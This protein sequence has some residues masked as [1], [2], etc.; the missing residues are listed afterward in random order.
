MDT[1]QPLESPGTIRRRG[2]LFSIS[3][4]VIA[5][6]AGIGHFIYL[7]NLERQ[8]GHRVPVVVAA[9][10]ISARTVFSEEMLKVIELPESS[11]PEAPDRPFIDP[12]E[13]LDGNTTALINIMPG[14]QIQPNMVSSNL[15]KP[16]YRAVS[17][18]VDPVTSTGGS[19]RTGNY[20]DIVRSFVDAQECSTT[21]FLLQNVLVLD[22]NTDAL[23]P[24]LGGGIPF[25]P[26]SAEGEIELTPTII[27]T[28]ELDQEDALKLI[29]AENFAAELRLIVRRVDEMGEPAIAP[30]HND[31]CAASA[32]ANVR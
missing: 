26:N 5:I 2:W 13:L 28:L 14:Q 1:Q 11:L 19:V 17:I 10:T 31:G 4:V 20:V 30:V 18:A 15:I 7:N 3:A 25:L 21:E 6:I 32:T 24:D 16:G 23:A 27:V 9:T 29:H 8:I 22:V 12:G